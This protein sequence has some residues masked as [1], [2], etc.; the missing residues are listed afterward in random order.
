MGSIRELTITDLNRI[1]KKFPLYSQEDKKD[2]RVILE[3]YIPNRNI[4]IG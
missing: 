2:H 3:F 4:Y 1:F